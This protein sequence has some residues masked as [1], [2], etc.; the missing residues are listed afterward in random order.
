MKASAHT[1]K[2]IEEIQEAT[3]VRIFDLLANESKITNPYKAGDIIKDHSEVGRI[4]S[5]THKI[6]IHSVGYER[7]YKCT[8]LKKNLTPYKSQEE[9]YIWGSNIIK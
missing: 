3:K 2:A 9:I 4:I 7:V 6:A 1:C 5:C 8:R